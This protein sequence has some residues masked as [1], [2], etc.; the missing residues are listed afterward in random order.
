MYTHNNNDLITSCKSLKPLKTAIVH[1]V[2]P[3]AIEAMLQSAEQKLIDPI[4]IGPK[5][6]IKAAAKE[7]G[8]SVDAFDIISVEHSHAAVQKAVA[9]A[10][11]HQVDALMKGS[12]DT[13][14]L[15]SGVLDKQSGLRTGRRLSHV[16]HVLINTY[17][18][19]LLLTDAAVNI[20]PLLNDKADICRNAIDLWYA[21]ASENKRPKVAILAATEKV[22]A[23]IQ[24]TI[25]AACLCK[26]ADRGQIMGAELDGPLALDLAIDPPSVKTKGLISSVAGNADVLVM[27]DIHSANMVAKELTFLGRAEAAGIV[28]GAHVPII[29]TSRSDSVKTRLTSC[30]LAL[31]VAEAKRQGKIA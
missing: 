14:E 10:A 17:H 29:L 27:P 30:A 8:V 25:D 9:L 19:P 12:L 16:Y 6:R 26:M 5:T 28:M 21:I 24:A 4:L 22:K 15:L 11:D 18:K 7:M 1:P 23:N 31:H 20:A 2:M 3:L 13:A